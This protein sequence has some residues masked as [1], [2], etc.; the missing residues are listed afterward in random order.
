MKC[1]P[2]K[3]NMLLQEEEYALMS[4]VVHMLQYYQTHSKI[5]LLRKKLSSSV[6]LQRENNMNISSAVDTRYNN[7]FITF[8]RAREQTFLPFKLQ[9]LAGKYERKS[10]SRNKLI[11]RNLNPM[12][13]TWSVSRV[14]SL[15]GD[16]TKVSE[17]MINHEKVWGLHHYHKSLSSSLT[18]LR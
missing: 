10:E 7:M 17:K 11:W 2:C 16:Q 13:F 12:Y 3:A 18:E 6:S 1:I 8:N 14:W 15:G 9:W 5:H 4:L